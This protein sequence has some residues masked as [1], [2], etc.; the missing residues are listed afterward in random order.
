MTKNPKYEFESTWIQQIWIN[1]ILLSFWSTHLFLE[2][3]FIL[4]CQSW[5]DVYGP[6]HHNAVFVYVYCFPP[7]LRS[8]P[9]Y[10]L[11]CGGDTS[12][13]YKVYCNCVIIEFQFAISVQSQ[14]YHILDMIITSWEVTKG[15]THWLSIA[16]FE[17]IFW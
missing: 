3:S 11:F 2:L 7:D 10:V 12:T 15:A 5:Y 13:I 16:Y 1:L 6:Y 17:I 9:C 14:I 8:L 4:L